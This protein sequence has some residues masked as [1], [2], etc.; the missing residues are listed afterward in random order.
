MLSNRINFFLPHLVF[1]RVLKDYKFKFWGGDF[2][3][4]LNVALLAIPQGMAYALVAGLPIHYGILGSAI[5]ALMGSLWGGGKFITLGPTNATAVLLFGAFAGAGLIQPNGLT[6]TEGLMLLPLIMLCSGV[7]LILAAISRI[8]FVV[9]FVSRT[10]I[11]AYVTA[12]ACL[13]IANQSRHVLG[14]I[15]GDAPSAS[16]FVEVLFFLF[17]NLNTSGIL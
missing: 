13:I 10:V 17:T 12:A 5:A 11:T 1:S 4:G 14:I 7:F 8:S 15:S 2:R 16:T 9:Q 6:S 3:A